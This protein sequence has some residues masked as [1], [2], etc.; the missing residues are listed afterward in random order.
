MA[1]SQ[2]HAIVVGTDGSQTAD[3]AVQKAAQLARDHSATLHI[4][5]GYDPVEA[6]V[7]ASGAGGD[8]SA[9]TVPPDAR[10]ARVLDE[11]A[12]SVRGDGLDLQTHACRSDGADAILEIAEAQ[13]ADLIV[14][15]SR[16]MTGS[17]RFLL[18]SVPNKVSHHASCDV[19]IV[20]TR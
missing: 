18:G 14:V 17:R 12:V 13:G 20:Q 7:A 15:G 8:A 16:G 4:V 11:A 2:Y 1:D 5:S 6:K 19:L 3:Q 10:V 9:W